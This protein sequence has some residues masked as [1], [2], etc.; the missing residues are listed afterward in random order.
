MLSD[1]MHEGALHLH[2]NCSTHETPLCI[3]QTRIT[4]PSVTNP[5]PLSHSLTFPSPTTLAASQRCEDSEQGE[6]S[7]N[8]REETGIRQRARH[9]PQQQCEAASPHLRSAPAPAGADGPAAS[10][11]AALDAPPAADR[12]WMRGTGR[13]DGSWRVAANRAARDCHRFQAAGGRRGG[14]GGRA[15]GR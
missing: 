5:L 6:G 15:Q 9:C 10:D 12:R 3:T 11:S 14:Q 2:D 4:N 13:A 7:E 1:N 8:V